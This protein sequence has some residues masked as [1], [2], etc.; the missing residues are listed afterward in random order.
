[1]MSFVDDNPGYEITTEEEACN[2]I[3][4]RIELV[5]KVRLGCVIE[6]KGDKKQ[7]K[8]LQMSAYRKFLQHQGGILGQ[9]IV[10]YRCGQLSQ[11]AYQKLRSEAMDLLGP[12]LV[13]GRYDGL[14]SVEP[15]GLNAERAHAWLEDQLEAVE[16]ARLDCNICYPGNEARTKMEQET[17]DLC[18]M[19]KLGGFLGMIIA[20]HKCR[21]LDDVAHN[22]FRYRA[23]QQVAPTVVGEARL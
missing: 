18:L 19:V 12:S 1:M 8:K 7:T 11:E 15:D 6:L 4:E 10:L 16:H 21:L 22:E 3:A 9:L 2:W 23:M 5:K 13:V 14:S 20:L 17:A